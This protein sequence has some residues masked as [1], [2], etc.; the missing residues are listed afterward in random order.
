MIISV[1]SFKTYA[2]TSLPDPVIED[3]LKALELLVRTYTN[4]NFQKRAWT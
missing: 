3:K 2:D 4:N 1:E